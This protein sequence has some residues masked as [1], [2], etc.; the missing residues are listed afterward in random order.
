M[1]ALFSS[2][3]QTHPLR[4]KHSAVFRA[5][6]SLSSA[7]IG[8]K[9]SSDPTDLNTPSWDKYSLTATFPLLA[10]VPSLLLISTVS[11]CYK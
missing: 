6:D 4:D 3:G 11:N 7:G 8:G 9:T 5:I 2:L 1:F 10:C